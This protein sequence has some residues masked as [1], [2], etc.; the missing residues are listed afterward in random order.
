MAENLGGVWG[1][2]LREKGGPYLQKGYSSPSP[3]P[4]L[5]TAYQV[6]MAK[7]WSRMISGMVQEVLLFSV[8]GWSWRSTYVEHR[9]FWMGL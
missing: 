9:L 4:E 3:Y 1:T 7:I 5:P 2:Y 6:V 8:K